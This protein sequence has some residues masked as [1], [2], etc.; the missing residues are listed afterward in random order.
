[1]FPDKAKPKRLTKSEGHGP[2]G[3]V[4][5]PFEFRLRLSIAPIAVHFDLQLL[6]RSSL[7][8]HVRSSTVKY[9]SMGA[10]LL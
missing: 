5:V 3:T 10:Y 4:G 9:L 2:R 1:M 8:V 7:R 6:D